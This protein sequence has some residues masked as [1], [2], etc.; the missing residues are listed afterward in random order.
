[1]RKRRQSVEE[2][3]ETGIDITPLVDI[4]FIL[5]I[6]FIVTTSFVKTSGV[7]VNR[8]TASSANPQERTNIIV[9]VR[10]DGTVW[11]DGREIPIEGVRAEIERLHAR[12]PKGAVVIDADKR[13][14]TGKTIQ[15]L[16][17]VRSAGVS[18]VALAANR[19]EN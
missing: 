11:V 19:R 5:L 17:Q 2:T 12:N 3:E 9:A 4:V 16:D 7:E 14:L 15:V 13:A 6:F 8:A 10:S 18:N 1:M